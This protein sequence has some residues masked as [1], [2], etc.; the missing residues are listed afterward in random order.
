MTNTGYFYRP[1]QLISLMLDSNIS[2][3]GFFFY[4]LSNLLIHLTTCCLLFYLL[5]LF[6]AD[7]FKALLC[8]LIFLAHPLFNQAVIWVPARGDLLVAMFGLLSFIFLIKFYNSK[9]YIFLAA[10]LITFFLAV[11]TKEIA[12]LFPVIFVLYYLITFSNQKLNIKGLFSVDNI[13]AYIIWAITIAIYFI[14]RMDVVKFSLPSSQ[15][16]VF[17]VFAGPSNSSP[18]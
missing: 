9:N 14:L 5:I 7:K 11:F 15:A 17:Q 4:H 1:V 10:N 6:K 8:S 13:F 3:S 12:I 18:A 2:N 16:S